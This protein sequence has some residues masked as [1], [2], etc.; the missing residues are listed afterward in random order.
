MTLRN[1]AIWGVVV[2]VLVALYTVVSP[3]GK[4][5]PANEIT[6]S[7]LLQKIDQGEVKSV[8]L[9]GD[10]ATANDGQ[11]TSFIATTPVSQDELLKRLE[12]QKAN[13]RVQSPQS[14]TWV[15]LLVNLLPVILLVGA[16]VIFMRQMQGAGKGAMGFG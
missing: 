8:V 1:L 2:A 12:Q 11:N 9:R 7:Q 3:G 14:S 5:K 6:Y 16:W 4:T 13:I 10:S 15:N